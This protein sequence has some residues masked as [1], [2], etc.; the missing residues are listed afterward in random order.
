MAEREVF[1]RVYLNEIGVHTPVS[2]ALGDS[3]AVQA[4]A[5]PA[6][7]QVSG[8]LDEL[9]RQ[10][11]SCRLCRLAEGRT[12]VVFGTG[13]PHAEIVFIGEAPGRDEDLQGEP[14]VGR[15][16]KLLDKMMMAV[17]LDRQNVYI[18]NTVKCR[19]PNNR[20]PQTD[21]V[22]TCR[23]WFD[24]QLQLLSPKVICLL[25]RVAAQSV[26]ESDAPLAALRGR[27]HDYHGIPVLVTYHPA[28][29]LRSPDQKHRSWADL[30]ELRR[31]LATTG[32]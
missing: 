26:L 10:A 1:L 28:F 27:W 22:Q 30:L 17:G 29:L 21:E 23:H 6:A 4:S 13:N 5:E 12:Q 2:F 15:A 18:M 20:D 14:F 16:G 8:T 19:P 32:K 7:A 3:D 11:A 24:A 9:A 31:S 25:G